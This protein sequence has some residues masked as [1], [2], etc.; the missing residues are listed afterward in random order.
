MVLQ[1]SLLFSL[2]LIVLAAVSSFAQTAEVPDSEI[3][4]AT[5]KMESRTAV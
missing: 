3:P 2:Q 5:F 4:V 1:R